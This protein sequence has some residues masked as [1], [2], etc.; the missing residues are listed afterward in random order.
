MSMIEMI[1]N[2]RGISVQ[3]GI[4]FTDHLHVNFGIHTRLFCA[5]RYHECNKR[6]DFNRCEIFM[7]TNVMKACA[8][9]C[10]I[11]GSSTADNMNHMSDKAHKGNI[12]NDDVASLLRR[13]PLVNVEGAGLKSSSADNNSSSA[14][15]PFSPFSPPL[16]RELI[17]RFN[18][19]DFSEAS[20]P[21]IL[22][23]RNDNLLT[24]CC[25]VSV[26][27]RDEESMDRNSQRLVSMR[28]C[29]KQWDVGLK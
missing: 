17:R 10:G 3:C 22:G 5:T 4:H 24:V 9:A 11:V 2:L 26:Y 25:V 20:L 23:L 21:H 19:V 7:K 29:T 28:E 16:L 14:A 15:N 1:A 6:T 13:I 8:R 12:V 18:F 27:C